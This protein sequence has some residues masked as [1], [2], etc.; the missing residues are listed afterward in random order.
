MTSTTSFALV[1]P[2]YNTSL[3][4]NQSYVYNEVG[5]FKLLCLED[6]NDGSYMAYQSTFVYQNTYDCEE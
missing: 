2:P 5:S 1:Q 3:N 4:Q 6:T